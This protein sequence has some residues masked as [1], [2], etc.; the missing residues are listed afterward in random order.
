LKNY[1]IFC[2]VEEKSKSAEIILD[3]LNNISIKAYLLF[4][5]YSLNFFNNFNAIFQSRKVL[6]HKLFEES[7]QLINEIGQN[8][9]TPE[10]LQNINTLNINDNK[11]ILNVNDIQGAPREF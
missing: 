4:L 6:I 9:L 1:F 5:K 3:Q 10:S 8:F 7:Q 2:V 11:N